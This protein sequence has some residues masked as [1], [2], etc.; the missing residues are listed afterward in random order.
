MFALSAIILWTNATVVLN[1]AM[2]ASWIWG[3]FSVR[4]AD[5]NQQ[6]R[7]KSFRGLR[8]SVVIHPTP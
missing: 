5:L 7:K 2:S 6:N 3:N 4:F 8:V 1:E